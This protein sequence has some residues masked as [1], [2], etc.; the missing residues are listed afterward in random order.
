MKS[1]RNRI[2]CSRALGSLSSICVLGLLGVGTS[3][4]ARSYT[5]TT[6]PEEKC[7]ASLSLDR[8]RE[9]RINFVVRCGGGST[10]VTIAIA[11]LGYGEPGR[12]PSD[13]SRAFISAGEGAIARGHCRRERYL[14]CYGRRD[15]AVTFRGWLTMVRGQRC[16]S[17]LMLA[18]RMPREPSEDEWSER[19]AVV[20]P[21][22][23]VFV[24]L[25]RGFPLGCGK[26]SRIH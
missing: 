19:P 3:A 14:T 10:P 9:D 23:V 17:K 4:N 13:Y 12:F 26:L 8:I 22:P 21:S 5:A 25:F 2:W 20:V 24:P 1:V 6:T 16:H 7:E 11:K 18:R 15:G